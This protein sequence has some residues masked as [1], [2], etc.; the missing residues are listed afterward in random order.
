MRYRDRLSV[1]RDAGL[2]KLSTLTWRATLLS[3]VGVVGF[4]NL[5]NHAAAT[6][7]AQATKPSPGPAPGSQ[8]NAAARTS[9]TPSASRS[10]RRE[11]IQLD[12]WGYPIVPDEPLPGDF[13]G[14]AE[15]ALASCPTLALLVS[16]DRR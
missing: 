11:F 7:A 8:A 15:M 1:H 3:A 5:F 2:R 9:A 10:S 4:M 13:K 6:T 16:K 14:L 12:P